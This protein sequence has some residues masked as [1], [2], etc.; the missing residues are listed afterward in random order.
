MEQIKERQQLNSVDI[1]RIREQFLTIS[2]NVNP[3][4]V[5]EEKEILLSEGGEDLFNYVDWLGL[6][7]ESEMIVL[8]SQRHYFYSSEDLRHVSTVVNLKRLN[9]IKNTETLLSSICELIPPSANFV[10]C[11][12]ENNRYHEYNLNGYTGGRQH[13]KNDEALEH[14]IISRIPVVNMIYNFIDAKT[15]RHMT[16]DD[17]RTLFSDHGFTVVDMTEMNGTVYFCARK[18]QTG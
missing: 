13:A 4:E 15:N 8:S 2:P 3:A 14:G 16:R 7:N 9:E 18:K 1:E 17:V 12:A 10:G 11:F 5:K 6:M